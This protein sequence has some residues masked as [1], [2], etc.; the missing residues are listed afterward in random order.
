MKID[1]ADSCAIGFR[2]KRDLGLNPVLPLVWVGH[3]VYLSQPFNKYL[4]FLYVRYCKVSAS[5]VK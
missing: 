2:N 1:F 3:L 5:F 4:H